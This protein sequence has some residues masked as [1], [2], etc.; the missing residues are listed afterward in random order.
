[1]T[2]HKDFLLSEL[3]PELFD[4]IHRLLKNDGQDALADELM[5]TRIV[6]KCRCGD[7]FCSSIYAVPKPFGAWGNGHDTIP[8]DTEQG[9]I[10]LD[11]VD[12]KIV[13]IEV[14]DRPDIKKMVEDR[15]K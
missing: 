7:G 15:I 8:L 5:M 4:E 2:K 10:N 9:M 14:L 6:D 3:F 11:I 12:G 13:H 1:M